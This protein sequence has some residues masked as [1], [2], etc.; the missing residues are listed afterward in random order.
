[1]FIPNHSLSKKKNRRRSHEMN[2]K[3]DKEEQMRML[4]KSAKRCDVL[5]QQ[6]SMLRYSWEMN[7][8]DSH[9]LLCSK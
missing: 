4:L 7:S 1:M 9:E 6:T 8:N 5:R 3:F 2:G